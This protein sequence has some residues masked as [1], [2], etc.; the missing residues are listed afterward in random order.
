MKLIK[1]LIY[2]FAT[3][4]IIDVIFSLTSN[5]EGL[6]AGE[7][8]DNADKKCG[9]VVVVLDRFTEKAPP[10]S[11]I[12]VNG[13]LKN[14]NGSLNTT[15]FLPPGEHTI[16]ALARRGFVPRE[17]PKKPGEVDNVNNSTYGNPRKVVCRNGEWL[18]ANFEL[19]SYVP[20]LLTVEDSKTGEPLVGAKATFK[21]TY[22]KIDRS[23]PL[24][25][26]YPAYVDWANPFVSDELGEFSSD[27]SFVPPLTGMLVI[28]KV[29][30]KTKRVKINF[31]K[32]NIGN[33][34]DFGAIPME[35][36]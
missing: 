1:K 3:V 12:R 5:F 27:I 18:A 6:K 22:G 19:F 2:L 32:S 20:F 29:G 25:T 17:D 34:H 10:R 28:Q 24:I 26:G 4:V 14:M 8:K 16:E 7:P 35:K 33:L 21:G 31:N 13:V 23:W 15:V 30:Y 11:R 36:I 9:C